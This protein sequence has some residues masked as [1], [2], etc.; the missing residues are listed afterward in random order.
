MFIH[1]EE[2][3]YFWVSHAQ[4]AQV[5]SMV[6]VVVLLAASITTRPIVVPPN[7]VT[8]VNFTEMQKDFTDKMQQLYLIKNSSYLTT[9]P[10][11]R[12]ILYHNLLPCEPNFLESHDI[13]ECDIEAKQ[14]VDLYLSTLTDAPDPF[15]QWSEDVCGWKPFNPAKNRYTT[16]QG[17]FPSRKCEL[18]FHPRSG[19]VLR[20]PFLPSHLN[21]SFFPMCVVKP[22]QIWFKG[23]VREDTFAIISDAIFIS[24]DKRTVERHQ[25]SYERLLPLDL[26]WST[27]RPVTHH[28]RLWLGHLSAFLCFLV[29]LQQVCTSLME[30][31]GGGQYQTYFSRLAR[32]GLHFILIALSLGLFIFF[33]VYDLRWENLIGTLT[34]GPPSADVAT[35]DE[36]QHFYVMQMYQAFTYHAGFDTNVMWALVALLLLQITDLFTCTKGYIYGMCHAIRRLV[37]P[38]L[39][40]GCWAVLLVLMAH[41]FHDEENLAFRSLRVSFETLFVTRYLDIRYEEKASVHLLILLHVTIFLLMPLFVGL[42]MANLNVSKALKRGKKRWWAKSQH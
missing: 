3:N 16:G 25:V 31:H 11:L 24:K 37:A 35:S 12:Q 33:C 23:H 42:L 6:V 13:T 27:N 34:M 21:A 18:C 30:R 1:K 40:A 28:R 17:F 29:L 36:K 15:E 8:P 4:L 38:L 19:Y 2:H 32:K 22:M 41:V 9:P 10:I 26:W 5:V 39:V 20:L 14:N 7:Y